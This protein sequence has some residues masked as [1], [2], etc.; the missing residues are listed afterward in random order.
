[1]HVSSR[2]KICG[3]RERVAFS[4]FSKCNHHMGIKTMV[5]RILVE[6]VHYIDTLFFRFKIVYFL[7]QIFTN[8]IS[9]PE[10]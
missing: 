9:P 3:E 5:Q 2:W 10:F 8:T 1:M 6:P 4:A 7:F